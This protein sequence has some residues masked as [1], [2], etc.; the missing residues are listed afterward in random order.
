MKHSA[1]CIAAEKS[2]KF[3]APRIQGLIRAVCRQR[4]ILFKEQSTCP[5][6]RVSA[7]AVH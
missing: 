6:I 4:G 2:L 3:D 5:F 7:L 1:R